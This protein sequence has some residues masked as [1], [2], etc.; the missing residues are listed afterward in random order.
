MT[1]VTLTKCNGCNQE[2]ETPINWLV[3]GIKVEGNQGS[4]DEIHVCSWSCLG[5]YASRREDEQS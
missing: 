2:T 4:G 1:R 3:V 5:R